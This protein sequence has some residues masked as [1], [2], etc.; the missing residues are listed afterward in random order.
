MS[1]VRLDVR[2]RATF[3]DRSRIM[4]ISFPELER[5]DLKERA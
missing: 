5:A 3:A 4:R 2:F 1:D